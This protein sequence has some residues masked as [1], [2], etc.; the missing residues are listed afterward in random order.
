MSAYI[1]FVQ[2]SCNRNNASNKC[3]SGQTEVTKGEVTRV[4]ANREGFTVAFPH[5]HI[6]SIS[7]NKV[8]SAGSLFDKSSFLASRSNNEAASSTKRA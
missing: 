8:F 2:L 5:R 4:N 1:L 6:W 7:P 3:T